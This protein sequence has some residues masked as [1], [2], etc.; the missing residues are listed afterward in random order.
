MVIMP[1]FTWIGKDKVEHHDK[2][3]P[4]RV[5]K[6]NKE[7]SVGESENLL[8]EGDNLEALKALMPFYY[9][10]V[11]CVYIDPPYNTGNEKWIYNDKVNAPQIKAWLNKVVGAEGEDLCRH[12][13]WLCMMYP[14]LKLL[15]ELLAEDGVI[16]VSIDDNEQS[17]LKQIMDEIFGEQNFVVNII[18]QK[19]YAASND[20]KYFSDNHDFILCYVKNKNE[21]GWIR[22]LLPRTEKQNSLYKYDSNDGKGLWRPDNLTVKTYSANYDYPITN[23]VTGKEYLP[24]NGRSWM[25]N[26]N[27]I[28]KWIAE[29]RVFF[30]KDG[31]GAP[32]L[33]RYLNEVQQGTVPLTIWTYDE[34]GHTDEARKELKQIFKEEK[35]PFQ[36]PKPTRLMKRIIQL[37]TNKE[38]IILDSFAGSGTTGQAVLEL[39]KD[40]GGNRKF[41]LVELENDIA[42]NVTAKRLHKV[43]QGYEGAMFPKGT[44]Q[45]LQYL[46]LN[47][48]LFDNGGFINPN[49]QY[50]D[51]ASYIYFT[52]THSYLD[53]TA[54]KN[55]YLGSMGQS[56]YFLLFSSK[57]KNILDDKTVKP[58][59]TQDG[60]KVIYADK[61]LLDEE[62]CL[63]NNIIFKQ[64]PYEL[65]KF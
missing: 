55:S 3:L 47:G 27:T 9:N 32:Q 25:T 12:D 18:W 65:K 48:E 33:K 29:G 37:A 4:F 14:R 41:I 38:G 28:E 44:G 59:L 64:I 17:N 31:K 40:D 23:P 15:R 63:K 30:G 56:H 24:T 61:C 60:T 21:N 10:K 8:I 22:N 20:A 35:S 36:T 1:Q 50:E 54:I 51:L 43:I 19:K 11:K 5:L 49:A 46:D 45:G 39:N 7:L 57:D 62:F 26:K 2:D 13:K 6:P 34:V 58:M 52:E 42:R 16:F 53:L